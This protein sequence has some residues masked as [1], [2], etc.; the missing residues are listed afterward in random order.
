MVLSIFAA[1]FTVPLFSIASIAW[2][3]EGD[4]NSYST[5]DVSSNYFKP[6]K[7]CCS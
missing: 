7:T 4:Y 5:A 6:F 2:A 3:L 1:I